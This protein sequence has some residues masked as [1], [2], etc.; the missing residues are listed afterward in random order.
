METS[1]EFATALG[2]L[3]VSK[4][5]GPANHVWTRDDVMR[6]IKGL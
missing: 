6:V 2:A 3:S 1:L 5:G 4:S